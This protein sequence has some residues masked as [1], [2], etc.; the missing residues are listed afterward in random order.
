[1]SLFNEFC[2]IGLIHCGRNPV[3]CNTLHVVRYPAWGVLKTGGAFEMHHGRDVLHEIV[4]F[5]KDSVKST[6][7]HALSPADFQNIMQE[8]TLDTLYVIF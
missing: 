8:G 7:L 6:N 3:L 1:M 2:V 4:M 5:A